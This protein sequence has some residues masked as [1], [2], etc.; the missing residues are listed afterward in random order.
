MELSDILVR[1]IVTEKS[2]SDLGSDRTYAFEVGISANKVQIS[3][4][5]KSFYG[6]DVDDVRTMIVRGKVKRFG[7]HHGRRSNWKKAYVTLS[8][9][10]E[11]NLYER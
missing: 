5:V 10:H 8:E 7:K 2:T 9:G 1:P 4:A 6:V 3:K 11:L